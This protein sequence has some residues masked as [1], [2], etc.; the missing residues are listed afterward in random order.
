MKKLFAIL[1]TVAVMSS[2]N[3]AELGVSL[4]RD[5]ADRDLDRAGFSVRAPLNKGLAV[6]TGVDRN[7]ENG[8]QQDRYSLT[9]AY[10]VYKLGPVSIDGRLGAAYLH[11]DKDTDGLVGT[12]G[13]GFRL[14]VTK[15]V[16]ANAVVGRVIG[17]DKMSKFDTNIVSLGLSYKF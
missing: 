14:P 7:I 9:V 15:T 13:L 1:S 12:V 2:V 17:H 4:T 5:W 8:R 10:E 16:T 6:E 3:A 11:N